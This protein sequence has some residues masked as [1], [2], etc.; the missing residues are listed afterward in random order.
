MP[1]VTGYGVDGC[2]AGWFY[3]GL[4]EEGFSQG[5][6]TDLEQLCALLPDHSRLLL[7]MPIGL[8]D[9]DS[10]PR[11]CDTAARKLLGRRS[12]SVFG[13]PGRII[14]QETDYPRANARSR[15][16]CGKGLSKQSFYIMPRIAAVDHLMSQN[17][18][19][20]SLIRESHP[21]LCFWGLSGGIGLVH[22][23]KHP[24]GFSER[25]SLLQKL[26]ARVPTI[27]EQALSEHLRRDVA[28]DDIL[29]ACVL[30]LVA[31]GKTSQRSVPGYPEADSRG[32]PMEI[33]Y[34]YCER[35]ITP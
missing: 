30:A 16:L 35:Q 6:V 24:A 29:D 34:G 12:S 7:D 26:D 2:R 3:V 5:L 11:A 31:A 23:K 18:R 22:G 15:E 20:R 27:V 32:L 19:A 4:G 1:S 21:E 10:R 33:V 25:L 8:R 14:L 28:R 9:Q 13:V 17:A